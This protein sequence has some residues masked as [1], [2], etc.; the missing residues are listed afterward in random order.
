MIVMVVVMTIFERV[1]VD[2]SNDSI[3]PIVHFGCVN[4]AVLRGGIE[5]DRKRYI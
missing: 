3:Y 4:R 5:G 2:L 1:S